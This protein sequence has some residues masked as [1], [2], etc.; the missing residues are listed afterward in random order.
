MAFSTAN[1]VGIDLNNPAQTNPSSY[2]ASTAVNV[3]T[4]G[5][6]GME[7]FGSDG[8][9]YVFAQANASIPASTTACTVNATTFLVTASGGSYTSPPVALS[10]GDFAWF[11][12]ASV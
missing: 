11:G 10:S 4:F 12:K 1:Q 2:Y 5:P 8:K 3:P 9:I 6:L 7:V